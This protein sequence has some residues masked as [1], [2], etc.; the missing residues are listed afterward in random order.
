MPIVHD[1]LHEQHDQI[2]A[3]FGKLSEADRMLQDT[4]AE[5]S[6]LGDLGDLVTPEDVIKGAGNLV[7]KGGS[8]MEIAKL[9]SDLPE[10]GPQIQAWLAGHEQVLAQ[11]EAALAPVLAEG[12]HALGLASMRVLAGHALQ[13]PSVPGGP[14]PASAE[15]APAEPGQSPANPLSAPGA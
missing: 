1:V 8:P 7:A 11:H 10:S 4:R 12:R 14:S 5:L 2:K 9:L 3:Q 15:Q 13:P 6:R